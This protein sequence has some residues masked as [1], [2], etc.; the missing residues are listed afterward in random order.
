M[1]LIGVCSGVLYLVVYLLQRALFRNGLLFSF[2][3]ATAQGD[4]ASWLRLL[5]QCAAYYGATIALFALYICLLTLCRQG[6]LRD[7]RACAVALLFPALF[8]LGLLLDQ[9]Y[10]SIDLFSYIAYGSLGAAPG[11]NPY[12]EPVSAVGYSPLGAHLLTYGWHPLHVVPL[13]PYG[14]LWV[15]LETAILRIT[16]DVPTDILLLKGLIV[17]ASLGSAA[18]IWA[19]LGRVRP[20]DQLLGTLVYLWNPVIIVEFA[21]EGHN[22]ALVILCV[23]T[24]L[25]L[26]VAARPALAIVMLLLAV[27]TKYVPL[28]LLPAQVVYFWSTWRTRPDRA[29]LT[30][31]L[32]LGLL[33]GFMLSVVLYRPFWVGM[34]TFQGVREQDATRIGSASTAGVVYWVIAH[35]PLRAV[36]ETLTSALLDG[37]FALYVLIISWRV[38]NI[39]ALLRACAGIAVAYVLL[40]SP[41][42]WP[43]YATLPLALFAL[44]PHGPFLRIALVLSFGARLAAPLDVMDNRGFIPFRLSHA[45]TAA[46]AVAPPLVVCLLLAIKELRR[47][48]GLWTAARGALRL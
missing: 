26:T 33:A 44:A 9:P 35:S 3:G 40:V 38:R 20:V 8:N 43:W 1:L 19:I 18:L 31:L 30:P 45:I 32:L 29:R 11:G 34:A 42:Y 7:R 22:D 25:F 27:L 16:S 36:A 5:G 4:P 13:V 28:I 14:P 21:G 37:I 47:Q 6:K 46:V 41:A 17:A 24:A 2:A 48:G 12:I 23:L 39:E 15:Q 10:L